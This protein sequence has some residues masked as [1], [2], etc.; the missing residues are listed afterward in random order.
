M[1]NV[2]FKQ[3]MERFGV[4]NIDLAEAF[5]CGK[6]YISEIRTG[7]CNPPIDRFWELLEC[8][9][10]LA[11]GAKSYFAGLILGNDLS[12]EDLATS[13]DPEELVM[14]MNQ[15]Q[16]SRIMFAIGKKIIN[17]ENKLAAI[18]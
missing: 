18:A 2:Y 3:T 4:K 11:P 13:I 14:A 10:R 15:Q 6:N 17:E 16:L 9:E 7:R 5:G 12:I 8:M 1:L